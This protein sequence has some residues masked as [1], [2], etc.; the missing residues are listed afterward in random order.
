MK[1]FRA[2]PGYGFRREDHISEQYR[3]FS[4]C[5]LRIESSSCPRFEV[6]ALLI[7]RR[8]RLNNNR[9][10]LTI[11]YGQDVDCSNSDAHAIVRINP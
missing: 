3:V 1:S 7:R 8:G 2:L 11:Y 6:G 5:N 4:S 9:S 10:G